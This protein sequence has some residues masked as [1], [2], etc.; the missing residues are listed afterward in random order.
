MKPF[1][2]FWDEPKHIQ[3]GHFYFPLPLPKVFSTF[4]LTLKFSLL[5][6]STLLPRNSPYLKFIFFAPSL[7]LHYRHQWN[8]Q[9]ME[10]SNC[11]MASCGMLKMWSAKLWCLKARFKCKNNTH[12]LFFFILSFSWF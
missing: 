11:G 9:A 1:K 7:K 8:T 2:P 10:C 6:T 4:F 3:V 12:V 5:P